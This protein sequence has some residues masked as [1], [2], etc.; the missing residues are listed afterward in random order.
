L[1]LAELLRTLPARAQNGRKARDWYSVRNLA[2][3]EAEVFI[4]DFIGWDPFFGGVSANE[5]VRELRG[6]NATKIL[7]RI[8]SPGGDITEA[9]AIRTALEEHP[10]EIETHVDGLAASSASWVGLVGDKVVIAPHA[11]MMI[12]EPWNV[13]AA[14]AEGMRKMAEELDVFGGEIAEM[15]VEKAGGS[16]D[17][18]RGR[19]REETWYTD[20]EAVDA[21]LADEIAGEAAAQNRYDPAILNIFKKTPEHLKADADAAGGKPRRAPRA[22]PKAAAVAHIPSDEVVREALR[23]QRDQ[24]RRLGVV[25]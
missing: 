17:E 9:V 2:G 20:Q 11:T 14:D 19:M 13:I 22:A 25:A 5:F 24:S 12:H 1:D 16:V 4:Y 21:G 10:A 8:N 7:L 3:G 6:L 18:W 23:F 15:Y